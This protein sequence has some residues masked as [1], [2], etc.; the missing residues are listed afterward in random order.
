MCVDGTQMIDVCDEF[1]IER[2]SRRTG[3]TSNLSMLSIVLLLYNHAKAY[4]NMQIQAKQGNKD[5]RKRY[6][7]TRARACMH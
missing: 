1:D 5:K 4:H 7:K 3:G 2:V 6:A